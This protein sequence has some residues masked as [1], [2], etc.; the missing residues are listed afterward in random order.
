MR[1]GIISDTHG[2]ITAWEK[3]VSSVFR[4]VE[5]IIHAGDVLYHG[6][7]NPLPEGYDPQ[8]LAAAINAS[9]VPIVISRGNCD[10]EVD[11]LLV[12]WPLQSP[13]AFVQ[14]ESLRFLVN[15]GHQLMPEE[16]EAQ[17]LRYGVQLFVFGHSH[18]PVI[19][20][21]NNIILLNPGSPSLS[22]DPQK[23][24]TVALVENSRLCLVD[25][26][27]QDIIHEISLGD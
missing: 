11:Q 3:V 18:I 9:G 21:K 7:R 16:M 5:L 4:N 15:H 25:I 27:T 24:Q 20:R 10:A 23:R 19:T 2:S 1:I 6:P 8:K 13:Y 26:N 14:I 22:K 17:A 12:A